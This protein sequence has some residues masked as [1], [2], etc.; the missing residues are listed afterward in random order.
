MLW[1]Y[2]ENNI[3]RKKKEI[4]TFRVDFSH[5][6]EILV[7][8]SQRLFVVYFYTSND[9]LVFDLNCFE[10]FLNHRN[11]VVLSR[12]SINKIH[13]NLKINK[14]INSI[15]IIITLD[16][17]D[18]IVFDSTQWIIDRFFLIDST[19][20]QMMSL[21]KSTNLALIAWW[22]WLE[23]INLDLIYCILQMRNR[24]RLEVF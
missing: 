4:V 16:H 12:I 21:D 7:L 1:Y 22:C 20:H 9:L 10:K 23:M 5:F 24:L 6:H 3:V 2:Y 18:K 13:I 8:N 19:R 17:R 14:M 15:I 11:N